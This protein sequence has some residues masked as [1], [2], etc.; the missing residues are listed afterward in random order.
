MLVWMRLNSHRSRLRVGPR[1]LGSY[2]I[3]SPVARKLKD[4]S[5]EQPE[6]EK[7]KGL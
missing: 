6:K 2:R 5:R 3:G 1:T 4:R 7:P